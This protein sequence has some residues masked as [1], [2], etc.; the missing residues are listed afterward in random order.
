MTTTATR[1][2]PALPGDW[3]DHAACLDAPN[4]E[5]FSPWAADVRPCERS[6]A[7]QA[8]YDADVKAALEWCEICPV[9]DT[10]LAD[11]LARGERLSVIGGWHPD[12]LAAHR[13][14]VRRNGGP[15]KPA[16]QTAI[17]IIGAWLAKHPGK[18]FTAAQLMTKLR[19]PQSSVHSAL[20][21]LAAAGK[22]RI[23]KAK[24]GRNPAVWEA[25][26]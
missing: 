11:G 15:R 26:P 5:V 18:T 3:R 4:A 19:L 2:A 7:T 9:I 10:C 1:P 21:Q 6:D 16:E 24:A 14:R 22:V 17:A 13:P 8:K 25:T 12:Q 20:R 23:F